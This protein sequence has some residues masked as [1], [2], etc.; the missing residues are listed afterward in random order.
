MYISI[1]KNTYFIRLLDLQSIVYTYPYIY[2]PSTKPCLIIG[3]VCTDSQVYTYIYIRTYYIIRTSGQHVC[4]K[5][6]VLINFQ[7]KL[8]KCDLSFRVRARRRPVAGVTHLEINLTT[9]DE[10][11]SAPKILHPAQAAL[12]TDFE[13]FYLFSEKMKNT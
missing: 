4:I 10:R 5:F 9:Q 12:P 13:L 6:R 3:I 8:L 1:L 11:S 7:K 2:I